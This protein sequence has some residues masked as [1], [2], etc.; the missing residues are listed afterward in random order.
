MI[1]GGAI[2]DAKMR[3]S[4]S[5]FQTLINYHF[6][7]VKEE[8][9]IPRFEGEKWVESVKPCSHMR[10]KTSSA[11]EAIPVL[12]DWPAYESHKLLEPDRVKLTRSIFFFLGGGGWG[13][14]VRLV[15]R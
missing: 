5:D 7:L 6:T 10:N 11:T 1:L 14:C 2:N 9:K 15:L 12:T 4:T 8:W 13:E 3:S